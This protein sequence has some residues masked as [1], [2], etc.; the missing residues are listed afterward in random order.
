M[1]TSSSFAV[2]SN[3]QVI[4]DALANFLRGD[5]AAIVNASTDDVIWGSYKNSEVPFSGM[6]YGKEGVMEF[7]KELSSNVDYSVFVLGKE[8]GNIKSNRIKRWGRPV[9]A[10]PSS[11]G[12]D[13]IH[14]CLP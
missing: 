6:Y 5:I 8:E 12:N 2:G 9:Y 10:L 14:F 3:G 11:G 1:N 13:K 4:Q 7:V